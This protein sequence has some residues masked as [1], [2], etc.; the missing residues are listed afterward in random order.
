MDFTYVKHHGT[1]TL[2]TFKKSILGINILSL[3][4]YMNTTNCTIIQ[5]LKRKNKNQTQYI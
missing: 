3:A 2:L 1:E 5:T 4:I